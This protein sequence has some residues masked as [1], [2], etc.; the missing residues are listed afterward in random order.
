MTVRVL[1]TGASSLIGDGVVR[2]LAARGDEVVCLQRGPVEALAALD[3]VE[4]QR[5]D[6]RDQVA[7]DRA[8]QGCNGVIHLAAKVGVVGESANSCRSMLR[9]PEI[10]WPPRPTLRSLVLSMCR[11]HR[12]HTVAKQSWVMLQ[13]RR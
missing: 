7:V 2:S 10:C 4:Q 1:V 3:G 6:I 8:A 11:L 5:G 9:A 12:S 13:H